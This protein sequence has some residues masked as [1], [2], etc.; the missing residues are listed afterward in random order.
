[1]KFVKDMFLG[2]Y[3]KNWREMRVNMIFH[4]MCT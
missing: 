1:M 2:K 4:W 3:K